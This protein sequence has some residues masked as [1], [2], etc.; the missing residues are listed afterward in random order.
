[1]AAGETAPVVMNGSAR[2]MNFER[3]KAGVE[4]EVS[5]MS[6][7]EVMSPASMAASNASVAISWGMAYLACF[8]FGC[9]GVPWPEAG[10]M[11]L[12]A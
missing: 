10:R 7:A 2:R 12:V 11:G 6:S 4:T 8:G 9:L 1:M 3:R 5:M